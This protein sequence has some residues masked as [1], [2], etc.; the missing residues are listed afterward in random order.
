VVD[1]SSVTDSV[2]LVVSP[3]PLTVTAA[4][5]SQP[6]GQINLAFTGA[7]TGVTNGDNI[8][9]AYNCSATANSPVGAYPIVPSLVD[10]D[11]RQTNYTI[12]LVNGTLTVVAVPNI[13]GVRQSDSSFTFTW[14]ATT[15]QMYQIQSKTTL[16]QPNWTTV[17]SPLMASNSTM[18]TS[19]HIGANTQQFYR[20]VLLP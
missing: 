20:V 9:A 7:I 15:N 17:G 11:S 8:T 4:N 12:N 18:I 1:F 10:S 3:A 16:T 19:E 5:S 6:Y 13:Q 2:I 14:S